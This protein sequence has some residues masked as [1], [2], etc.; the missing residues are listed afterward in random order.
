MSLFAKH[1]LAAIARLLNPLAC[2]VALGAIS[3]HFT[4]YVISTKETITEK[5]AE[6][7]E[8]MKNKSISPEIL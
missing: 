4:I 3:I 5:E 1:L 6:E 8:E 7:K 2:R